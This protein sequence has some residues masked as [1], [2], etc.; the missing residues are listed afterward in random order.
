MKFH[1][2]GLGVALVAGL[3]AFSQGPTT[4]TTTDSSADSAEAAT[5]TTKSQV[6][7]KHP[8]STRAAADILKSS[9]DVVGFRFAQPGVV[10]E[11]YGQSESEVRRIAAAVSKDHG[12]DLAVS[13]LIV[14]GAPAEKSSSR[15]LVE[16]AATYPAIKKARA[17]GPSAVEAKKLQKVARTGASEASASRLADADDAP[18]APSATAYSAGTVNGLTKIITWSEWGRG[19]SGRAAALNPDDRGLEM[20]ISLWNSGNTGTRP[21]CL[22]ADANNRFWFGALPGQPAIVSWTLSTPSLSLDPEFWG[23]YVDSATYFDSCE[24]QALGIGIGYPQ[25]PPDW[26]ND[27][28]FKTTIYGNPGTEV[29]GSPFSAGYQS[30]SNDCNDLGEE[31]STDCMGLNENAA[32]PNG[33]SKNSPTVSRARNWLMPNCISYGYGSEP[34]QINP[35]WCEL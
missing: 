19:T 24:R 2:V 1:S 21:F 28:G 3:V 23:A 25:D 5:S 29:G 14:D 32:M 33:W 4:A 8:I 34:V 35:A 27:G 11:I 7:L 6:K 13:S 15:R 17:G 12:I 22:P 31:P 30:V 26:N 18:W 9:D 16:V 20:E 10:G